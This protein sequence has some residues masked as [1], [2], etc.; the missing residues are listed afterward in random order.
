MNADA[1]VLELHDQLHEVERIRIEIFLEGCFLGDLALLDT[2]LLGQDLL[3]TL[4][5]LFA[6]R[7][8]VTSLSL[9][10]GRFGS[11]PIIHREAFGKALNDAV[12]DPPRA[13]TDRIRDRPAAGVA[14]GDHGEAA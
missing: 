14:M 13:E 11:A 3:D 9:C 7:C 2:E 1:L 8:H 12:L 10:R 5:Y 6:R 4:V